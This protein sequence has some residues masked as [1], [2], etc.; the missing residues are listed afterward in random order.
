MTMEKGVIER[1][2]KYLCEREKIPGL[3]PN[4]IHRLHT[5]DSREVVLLVDDVQA[6]LDAIRDNLP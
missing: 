3:H 5:G 2:Q 4:E 1:V 6:L